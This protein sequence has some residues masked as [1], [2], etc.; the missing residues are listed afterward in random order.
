MDMTRRELF[1]IGRGASAPSPASDMPVLATADTACLSLHGTACRVC[2]EWCESGAITF[3]LMTAGR[4]E[5]RVDAGRCDGCG[6]CAGRCPVGA[7][8]MAALAEETAE[9]A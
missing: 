6:D 2:G 3:R 4:A 8:R 7:I 5:V 9:C 1:R